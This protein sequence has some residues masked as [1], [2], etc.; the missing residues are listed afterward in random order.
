MLQIILNNNVGCVALTEELVRKLTALGED[1]TELNKLRWPAGASNYA[2]GTFLVHSDDAATL[3]VGSL[4]SPISVKMLDDTLPNTQGQIVAD[5]MFQIEHRPI[6]IRAND[7][8]SIPYP[9]LYAV[10]VVDERYFWPGI[11]NST[12]FDVTTTAD[13]SAFYTATEN[14]GSPYTWTNVLDSLLA[15]L[16]IGATYSIDTTNGGVPADFLQSSEPAPYTLDRVCATLGVILVANLS[17]VLVGGVAFRYAIAS[18]DS[19]NG[20]ALQHNDKFLGNRTAGGAV[21]SGSG[22]YSVSWLNAIMPSSVTVRFPRQR[23]SSLV[24][25]ATSSTATPIVQFFT[26]TSTSGKPQGGATGRT[27]YTVLVNDA[28]WAIGT[29]G[30]ETNATALQNRADYLANCYYARWRTGVHNVRMM[31]WINFGRVAG[32][33]S[34]SLTPYGPF[35]DLHTAADW[36]IYGGDRDVVDGFNRKNVVGLGGIQ[37]HKTFDG[38]LVISN[39]NANTMPLPG[40]ITAHSGGPVSWAYTGSTYTGA[41]LTV[42]RNDMEPVNGSPGKLGITISSA[43]TTSNGCTVKAIGVG[44]GVLFYPDPTVP[45][46][47]VFSQGNN[48]E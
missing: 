1:V 13:R 21:Y 17:P 19:L 26:A 44:A 41:T 48:A 31:G 34:W 30:S 18:P 12:S 7:A 23:Q 3:R 24:D 6:H 40:T 43:G 38:S 4:A 39:D 35:T 27:G 37:T 25:A 8:V 42:V 16:G 22:S 45:G 9:G 33:L 36:S 20:N 46:G 15:T 2:C 10:K 29:I 5:R 11:L 28:M 14:S 32:E 47:W